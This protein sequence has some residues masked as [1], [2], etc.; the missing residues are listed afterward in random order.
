MEEISKNCRACFKF[1]NLNVDKSWKLTE[2][3]KNFETTYTELLSTFTGL[4]FEDDLEDVICLACRQHLINCYKFRQKVFETEE[5][6]NSLKSNVN[7]ELPPLE[8]KLEEIK[9][10][11]IEEQVTKSSEEKHDVEKPKNECGIQIPITSTTKVGR[12]KKGEVR[13]K[14]RHMREQRKLNLQMYKRNAEGYF[15]C[16]KENC[17]GMFKKMGKLEDHLENKHPDQSSF[18]CETCNE[19]FQSRLAFK[20]HVFRFHTPRPFKCDICGNT[21][22]NIDGVRTH[23]KIHLPKKESDGTQFPC[24]I[25]GKFYTS[26]TGMIRHRQLVHP[27]CPKELIPKPFKCT[28]CGAAWT[29]KAI[30]RKHMIYHGAPQFFCDLCGKGFSTKG[31]LTLHMDRHANHRP[32]VCEICGKSFLTNYILSNHMMTHQ[33]ERPFKCSMCPTSFKTQ[34]GLHCH[35]VNSHPTAGPLTCD[36]CGKVFKNK[37]TLKDHSRIHGDE[38]LQ[39]PHCDKTYKR[40]H[41]LQR[42]VRVH[43]GFKK[44][45]ECTICLQNWYSKNQLIEHVSKSHVLEEGK[46]AEDYIRA[47][48]TS[49]PSGANLGEEPPKLFNFKKESVNSQKT[50]HFASNCLKLKKKTMSIETNCRACFSIIDTKR[51]RLSEKL[52]TFEET[53]IGNFL[54]CIT[55]ITLDM[56]TLEEEFICLSCRQILSNFFEFKQKVLA[57]D[58]KFRQLN[59]SVKVEFK[60]E[61]NCK[62]EMEIDCQNDELIDPEQSE[63]E[64][65][66]SDEC[67]I[68]QSIRGKNLHRK[69]RYRDPQRK[70]NLQKFKRNTDGLFE[71]PRE[72]CPGL[73]KN[74]GHLEMHLENKHPN[75]EQTTFPCENCDEVFPTFNLHKRHVFKFHTPRPFICDICGNGYPYIDSLRSHMYVHLPKKREKTKCA[76]NI[77]GKLYV[78]EANMLR[79]RKEVHFPKELIPKPYI[80]SI[81]CSAWATKSKLSAHM[82]S[83]DS[84][85]FFCDICSKGYSLKGALTLHMQTHSTERPFFCDICGKSYK[86]KYQLRDHQLT[87]NEERTLK[88]KMCPATFKLANSLRTHETQVHAST[89]PVSCEICGKLCKNKSSL[90]SH[91]AL[92]SK[93]DIACPHCDKK[94]KV[95]DT[96]KRHMQRTHLGLKKRHECSVCL[97][98]LWSRKHIADHIE[99]THQDVIAESGKN[100]DELVRKYWTSDP[101]GANLGEQPPKG[102]IGRPIIELK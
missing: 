6:F 81:C 63:R 34:S 96:L 91:S 16:P 33:D 17:S 75:T 12:P 2:K 90:K 55:G 56:K 95:L 94:Y 51:Y 37:G 93:N 42:H 76:C 77:C 52:N 101:S 26:Q 99:E 60:M 43:S 9:V 29:T 72:N 45:H 98:N 36:V 27:V 73:F 97:K 1:I 47:Y 83:H 41:S 39:C 69:R 61:Q 71:C 3:W 87:H 21:Y 23:M 102:L 54:M 30:L 48:W 82:K 22:H 46:A 38:D 28:I 35:E 50:K 66:K 14:R 80:C 58:K 32:K 10:E 92:H 85:E 25:C 53:T 59:D 64:D 86:T 13:Q 70:E 84:P 20:R 4:H 74:M 31:A 78:C 7:I 19:E 8:I 79:H 15:E 89:G 5:K 44:R 62:S 18:T 57:S 88:C 100:A 40:L 11:V 67:S 24:P 65:K 49:D 68:N